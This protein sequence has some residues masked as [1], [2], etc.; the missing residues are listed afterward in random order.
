MGESQYL[1]DRCVVILHD[2]VNN[3]DNVT[4]SE[5]M[6]HYIIK[7]NTLEPIIGTYYYIGNGRYIIIS[8]NCLYTYEW[9]YYHDGSRVELKR[10]KPET[11]LVIRPIKVQNKLIHYIRLI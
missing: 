4:S 2:V 3:F 1:E 10:C 8:K 5:E 6:V 9:C 7:R 11:I